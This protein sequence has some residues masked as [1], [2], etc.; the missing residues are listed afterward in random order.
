MAGLLVI[1][2]ELPSISNGEMIDGGLS[3]FSNGAK[4]STLDATVQPGLEDSKRE[5]A[6]CKDRCDSCSGG[7]IVF[8]CPYPLTTFLES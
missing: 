8:L 3:A 2:F 7:M 6:R 1:E 5:F 4:C